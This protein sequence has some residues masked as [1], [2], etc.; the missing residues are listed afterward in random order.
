MTAPSLLALL[1]PALRQDPYPTYRQWRETAPLSGGGDQPL[2]ATRQQDC[3]DVLRDAK[4][5]HLEEEQAGQL[6]S[7]PPEQ[8]SFLGLNPPDHT[9]LRGLVSKA[10]TRKVV[11]RLAPMISRT[12]DEL[13]DA[14]RGAGT[15]NLM[16]AIARPLPVA[17]ISELLDVP[18]EDRDLI[19]AWSHDMARGLDPDFLIP[20]GVRE[21]QA[22][23]RAEFRAYM[24]QLADKRRGN[25]G[26][27]LLSGLVQVHDG[28]DML[29]EAELLTTC[30]LLLIAG[31]E[32]T[33]NL[34]GNGT[35]ALLRNPSQLARLRAEPELAERAVEEF[36]RYDSP[37]QFTARFALQDTKIGEVDVPAGS[38]AILLL[39]AAN[40]DPELCEE[41]DTLDIGREP[42]RHLAFGHG[43]HFCLGAPL[44]RLEG[45]IM[46]QTLARLDVL[47]SAGEPS[48]NDNIIL[49]G[50][51]E[52][53]V[54][55]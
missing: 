42:T 26:E 13:I 2:M 11:E 18:T 34:I 14:A 32:T 7:T 36:L 38:S 3:S 53:P 48:Y 55:L 1:D 19:V 25:P 37:V 51:K 47:E 17:V 10:F 9:R 43:P 22:K 4:F 8:R 24:L 44:A 31:H 20:E 45:R 28:G 52:L 49:R 21:R 12:T 30:M 39:S 40:R 16:D 41:P 46:F 6:N 27:D 50:M 29:S 15:V 54:R 35:L 23:A 33:V 5:G